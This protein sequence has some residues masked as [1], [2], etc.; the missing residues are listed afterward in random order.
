MSNDFW[1]QSPSFEEIL[2]WFF[3][4]LQ[5]DII[6]QQNFWKYQYAKIIK[7]AVHPRVVKLTT[8]D[9]SCLLLVKFLMMIKISNVTQKHI[10]YFSVFWVFLLGRSRKAKQRKWSEKRIWK[11]AFHMHDRTLNGAW[12]EPQ[13]LSRLQTKR[14]RPFNS[15]W[16]N[17]NHC[18]WPFLKTWPSSWYL[19]FKIFR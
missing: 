12:T 6:C 18:Q 10:N 7:R 3:W 14:F 17:A 8:F 2:L 13:T 4:L 16:Q 11:E 19:K 9:L 15:T 1:L 5:I